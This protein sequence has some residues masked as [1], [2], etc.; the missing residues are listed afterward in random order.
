MFIVLCVN[1]ENTYSPDFEHNVRQKNLPF[2]SLLFILELKEKA[3][4]NNLLGCSTDYF[5]A[6]RNHVFTRCWKMTYV[7]TICPS[8][9]FDLSFNRRTKEY[10]IIR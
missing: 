1:P 6:L 5:L 2:K 7:R 3:R 10:L 9:L 4:F 8:N